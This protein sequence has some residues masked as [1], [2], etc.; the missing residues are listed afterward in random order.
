MY[1]DRIRR[2]LEALEQMGLE[3]MIVSDPDSIWYL[4]GYYVHPFERLFA[5]Y[6]RRDGKHKFF[7]N[8]LFPVPQVD[9]EQIWFSD[10][11]DYYA[12]MADNVDGTKPMGIDKDWAARFLL[13]LQNSHPGMKCVESSD[14]VD[15]ARACKD[16]VEQELM[17][18]SSRINDDVMERVAHYIKEG[19]TERQ[20]ADYIMAEY[21]VDDPDVS[22]EV[23]YERLEY[24]AHLAREQ[25]WQ[26]IR[27]TSD[28][29]ERMDRE[30][31]L[32]DRIKDVS[33]ERGFQVWYQPVRCLEDGRYC[34]MEALI[35][36]KE[37]DGTLISPGEFIPLAEETG[38]ITSVT[39]FVLEEACRLLSSCEEVAEV[40]VSVNLPMLQLLEPGFVTRLNSI[41]DRFSIGHER[42]C[43]EFTE[44]EIL[45]TFERVRAIMGELTASGYR[46]FLDDFGTGYSNYSCMLRLPF[47]TVKLDA[48]LLRIS[49]EKGNRELLPALTKLLH[50]L[51][52]Q[53]VAEGVETQS[54]VDHLTACGVDRIQGFFY[55][56]PMEEEK[57]VDFYRSRPSD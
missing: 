9:F 39:W 12:I 52:V 22:A 48:S 16:E 56:R 43:L 35:R 34:S 17:R 6:L 40:N 15:N 53:V 7:L 18:T 41:V 31:Y 28:I 11:D 36:L 3:Q 44:R 38:V 24:A 19:M 14:C 32:R 13:S 25:G 5:L 45:E 57:V 49:Q 33:R 37:E 51:G 47:H 29:G 1:E 20:V 23:F 55:A 50:D 8:K 21:V 54:E 2:V 46:F 30:Y 10:T 26:Y 42:I 4:T 27:Y